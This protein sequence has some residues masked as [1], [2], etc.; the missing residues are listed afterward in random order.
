MGAPH[1][2]AILEQGE[3]AILPDGTRVHDQKIAGP[4]GER[5]IA[6][7]E[8]CVRTGQDSGTEIQSV[9]RDVT[10]RA[11]AEQALAAA[12]DQADT[13][14]RAKSRFLAMVSHEIRTPLNGILGMADLL[15]DTPLA[16]EQITYTK[17]VR[18]SGET[19]LSL[20]EEILDFS[21]IEAGRLDLEA[22]PFALAPMV[23]DVAELLAPRAQPKGLEI[24][25]Y[26]DDALPSASLA[27]SRASARFSSTSPAMLLSSPKKAA[28]PS[29][30]SLAT[31][32]RT[33]ALRC[34]TPAS[35][36]RRRNR[37]AFSASSSR[38]KRAPSQALAEP[39]SGWPSA[40]ALSSAWAATLAS[41]AR[42]ALA[43]YLISPS[44]CR[45]P[46]TWTQLR[47]ARACRQRH[48]DR[49][50]GEIEASLIDA[51]PHAL[52][53]QH[54]RGLR[55]QRRAR[56]H[57]GNAKMGR[58]PAE[59]ALGAPPAGD[60]G[61]VP[62]VSRRIV[63]ITPSARGELAA[64][65]TAGFT[66]YLVKPVRAVSLAARLR[67]ESSIDHSAQADAI[68]ASRISNGKRKGL[69]VLVAEDNEINALLARALLGR[70]GIG[71]QLP[72][73]ARTRSKLFSRRAR[74]ARHSILSSWMCACPASMGSK[75]RAAS[76][77]PK[78]PAATNASRSLRLR[79]MHFPR[80]AKPVSPP[81]WMPSW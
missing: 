14:N 59:Q 80:T 9:G 7:R 76:A 53:A 52:G 16:P 71:R 11:H 23:E 1:T 15:L 13:A 27:T 69:A 63:L 45:R 62:D 58:R 29:R 60:P 31:G 72:A 37:S 57:S 42:P 30:S 55:Y 68:E 73:A 51:P 65:K 48:P 28:S 8:V 47:R 36:L 49:S 19:L 61:K 32:R 3:A 77:Q 38:R 41:R 66:D 24:A 26:V 39:D 40:S 35:V 34:A 75:P 5:W 78:R 22:R 46:T 70:L 54:D 12:R 17:A 67:G 81:A 79:Q 10:D 64:L 18:T 6:W 50:A 74:P 4:E 44:L 33:C 2:L 25:C 43:P 21:K 20:I 56:A